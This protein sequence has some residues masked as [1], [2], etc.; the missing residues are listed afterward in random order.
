[1]AVPPHAGMR[2]SLINFK[3]S[4]KV[5]VTLNNSITD[6][7]PDAVVRFASD[8]RL[9]AASSKF[10]ASCTELPYSQGGAEAM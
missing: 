1:M 2:T 5:V 6:I 10:C 7:T 4:L 8:G 3:A 9:M